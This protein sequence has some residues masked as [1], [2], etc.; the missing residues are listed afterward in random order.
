MI[1]YFQ[2]QRTKRSHLRSRQCIQDHLCNHLLPTWKWT[3]RTILDI[4][5]GNLLAPWTSSL[6]PMDPQWKLGP[7]FLH[8]KCTRS[9]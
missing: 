8:H 4:R 9:K 6:C 2:P 1:R 5:I 3:F 7:K